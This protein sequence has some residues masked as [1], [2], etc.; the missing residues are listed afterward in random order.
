MILDRIVEVKREEV[1]LLARSFDRAR[2]EESIGQ[3]PPTRGFRQAL[4]TAEDDVALIAEVKKASPSKGVIR[5]D[6]DPVGIAK[7]YERAGAH[8]LSV[9]TDVQ[10]FQGSP[11][12]LRQIRDQVELPLLRKDFVID[13]R[14]IYEARLLGADCVLLIA[15]ILS[16]EQIGEYLE[17]AAALGLDALVEVHDEEEMERVL[18]TKATLIGVNNRNLQDFTVDLRTTERLARMVPEGRLLVSESAIVTH[19]DVRFVQEAGARAILVGE[20]LMRD[21]LIVPSVE[22]LLGRVSSGRE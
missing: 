3:L 20:T 7:T 1:A 14:Q 10:F 21:P 15:A 19:D 8:C 16:T 9:L 6:F 12:F 5:A 13:E 22:A 4:A 2:V 18:G 17:V 11:E